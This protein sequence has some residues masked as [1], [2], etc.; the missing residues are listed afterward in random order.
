MSST[1]TIFSYRYIVYPKIGL[2]EDVDEG[3]DPILI[4]IT[5]MLQSKAF[6]KEAQIPD[7]LT[8]CFSSIALAIDALHA[9]IPNTR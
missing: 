6:N 3:K 4:P 7:L 5:E 1:K 9:P 2:L 8:Q